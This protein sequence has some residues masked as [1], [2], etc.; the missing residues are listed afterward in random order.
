[1]RW[2]FLT[3]ALAA[4]P[5]HAQQVMDGS[6]KAIDETTMHLIKASLASAVADPYGAQIAS[7]KVAKTRPELVCGFL[8]LK[9]GYGAYTGFRAF[10]YNTKY[11]TLM[12]QDISDCRQ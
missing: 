9:N 2:L 7:L 3:C 1:M 5:I 6:D 4:S 12:L 11:S 10:A 8:N